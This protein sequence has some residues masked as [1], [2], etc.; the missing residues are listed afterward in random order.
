M[1]GGKLHLIKL[2]VGVEDPG[3]LEL[4]QARRRAE[5]GRSHAFHVTRMWPR[6]EAEILAGGSLYWVMKGQVRARQQIIALEQVEGDD[7]IRRC[8]I[9]LQENVVRVVPTPRRAFQGW[10]Y[11][12]EEQAPPDVTTNSLDEPA[13]PEELAHEIALLGVR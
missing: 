10:R 3:E 4:W 5:T 12:P 8:A 11:L 1:A 9:I 13:L 6:R 2:C 7:G